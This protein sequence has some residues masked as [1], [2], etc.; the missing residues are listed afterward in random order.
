MVESIEWFDEQT[1]LGLRKD[2][3]N[4]TCINFSQCRHEKD[5][6]ILTSQAQQCFYIKDPTETNWHIVVR[7]P[8][9]DLFDMPN[10]EYELNTGR[11]IMSETSNNEEVPWVRGDGEGI[12]VPIISS[13][14]ELN[15]SNT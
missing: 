5:P 9:R 15:A 14:D 2:Q 6:F 3:Y 10:I 12:I 11:H 8:P 1:M 4:F 7:R 13:M